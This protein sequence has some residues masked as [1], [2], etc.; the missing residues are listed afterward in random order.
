MWDTVADLEAG[1]SNVSDLRNKAAQ[2][3]GADDVQVEIFEAPIFDFTIAAA[4]SES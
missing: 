3:A 4:A 1:D 2:S